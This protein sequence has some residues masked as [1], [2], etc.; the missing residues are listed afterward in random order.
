M[1]KQAQ[2]QKRLPVTAGECRKW[3]VSTICG[4]PI[5]CLQYH[6][7]GRF[8]VTCNIIFARLVIVGQD[9]LDSIVGPHFCAGGDE[10]SDS[11]LHRRQFG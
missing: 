7:F 4:L 8:F 10:T 9:H 2:I 6:L 11:E 1:Q 3:Q 5:D